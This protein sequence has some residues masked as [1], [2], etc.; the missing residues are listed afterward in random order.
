MNTSVSPK[1]LFDIVRDLEKQR[2]GKGFT[3]ILIASTAVTVSTW[4]AMTATTPL[5]FTAL[6]ILSAFVYAYA[7][8]PT[9]DAI[10]YTLTGKK[11]LDEVYARIISYP[12][13]WTHGTYAELHKIHHKMNGIEGRDPERKNPTESEY[14]NANPLL[15]FYYRNRFLIDVFLFA[16]SGLIY[17]N[18]RDGFRFAK[19]SRAVRRALFFDLILLVTLHLIL[20][21]GLGQLGMAGK[22]YLLF[23]IWERIA[24]GILHFRAHIEHDSLHPE[25]CNHYEVQISACRNIVGNELVSRYFN[26]LTYHSMHHAFPK[27]PFYNLKQAHK[28]IS[29][30]IRGSNIKMIE[31]EGYLAAAKKVLKNKNYYKI[32]AKDKIIDCVW[33]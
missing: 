16:G 12:I 10:H 15:R 18:L 24:G 27:I 13:F 19:T 3:K 30:E 33:I 25:G 29:K 28:R 22:F 26:R 6:A 8:I 21:V 17:V 23:L 2:T 9:H 32:D 14:F 11:W 1:K 5:S 31:A 4:L 20:I 7:L